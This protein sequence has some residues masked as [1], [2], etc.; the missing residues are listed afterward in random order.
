MEK[1]QVVDFFTHPFIFNGWAY[2]KN[3]NV[4]SLVVGI[5]QQDLRIIKRAPY[6]VGGNFM[7]GMDSFQFEG[8][9]HGKDSDNLSMVGTSGDNLNRNIL[10]N[11]N[12]GGLLSQLKD[13]RSFALDRG[14]LETFRGSEPWGVY[15]LNNFRFV[16][17]QDSLYGSEQGSFIP[18]SW[19]SP[20]QP[21]RKFLNSFLR[22]AE[23][24]KI[25]H[26]WSRKQ[27]ENSPIISE[28]S[29]GDLPF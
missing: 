10:L 19:G 1:I 18:F 13:N 2:S 14:R 6:W 21:N 11:L 17:A 25:V 16:L 23:E 12:F 4:E 29:V 20:Y 7:M 28:D 27:N 15:E 24:R 9:F 22:T 26:P 8:Y 3:Q 5:I